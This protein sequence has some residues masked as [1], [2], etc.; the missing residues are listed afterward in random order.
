MS[1]DVAFA[2]PADEGQAGWVLLPDGRRAYRYEGSDD[3]FIAKGTA[4]EVPA[5]E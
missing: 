5:S 3:V 2:P 1:D 4:A